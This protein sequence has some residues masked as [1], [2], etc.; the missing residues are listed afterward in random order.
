MKPPI[1]VL[2]AKTIKT[3]SLLCPEA[4]RAVVV[5]SVGIGNIVADNMPLMKRPASPY[6]MKIGFCIIL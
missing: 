1:V 3:G 4:S 2:A 6:F 5:I